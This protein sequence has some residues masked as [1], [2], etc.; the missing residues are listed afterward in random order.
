M[1]RGNWQY[2]A[3]TKTNYTKVQR[4]MKDGVEA[5]L[6]IALLL[7]YT[8]DYTVHEQAAVLHLFNVEW[9]RHWW[10][11]ESAPTLESKL[12][13][14]R[15]E[16]EL[17]GKMVVDERGKHQQTKDELMSDLKTQETEYNKVITRL[18]SKM[19]KMEKALRERGVDIG[20]LLS[21]HQLAKDKLDIEKFNGGAE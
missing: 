9:A 5:T 7:S 17:Y 6:C 12:E 10:G 2:T 11:H 19:I 8:E 15:R 20:I 14:A 21:K 18:D 16:A 4:M 3:I 13:C 1:K